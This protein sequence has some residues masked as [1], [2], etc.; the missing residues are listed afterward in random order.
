[1]QWPRCCCLYGVLMVIIRLPIFPLRE[2]EVTGR[3][4]HTTRDQVQAIV[5]AQLKGNF[6]TLDLEATRAAFQRLPW[7]RRANVR[8]QWPDRLDVEIEEHVVLARW[9]DSA[10]VNSLRRGVRSGDQRSASGFRSARG[11]V[12]RGDA[13]LRCLPAGVCRRCARRPV[14]V[15]LSERRAWQLRLD[16]GDVVELGRERM[17]E[18]LQ[19]FVTVY[20]HT[21]AQLPARAY[22]VDL[23]YPNGF[24]VRTPQLAARAQAGHEP[25]DEQAKG[26]QEP[27]RRPRHRHLE[28]RRHGG[29]DQAGGRLRRRRLRAAIRRAG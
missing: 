2:V 18:R 25:R 20:G 23:R 9:R 13:A 11:D 1:M 24:A 22:R 19:R 3:V 10:L 6:F 12:W 28:D 21:L 14:Q 5:A 15:L 16:D 7:V 4:A 26:Q 29:G 8:R 27:P 17:D